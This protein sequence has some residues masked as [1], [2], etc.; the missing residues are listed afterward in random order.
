MTAMMMI[1]LAGARRAGRCLVTTVAVFGLVL[2][3]AT[4]AG[5]ITSEDI[6]PL[7]MGME[8]SGNGLLDLRM[9]SHSGSEITNANGTFNGDNGNATLPNSGGSD[10]S[11]FIESYVTTVGDLQEYY[12]YSFPGVDAE[13]EIELTVFLDL[14]ETT[15]AN[16]ETNRLIKLDIILNPDSIDGSPSPSGDVSG[17][18][19]AAIDQGYTLGAGTK[20]VELSSSPVNLPVNAQGGG[21]GD[22]ALL[23]GI[24]PFDPT[25]NASDVLLFNISMDTL[26]NGG[27]KF[28][29]SGDFSGQNVIE[30]Q[31][32]EPS[33][34]LLLI[35][36]LASLAVSRRRR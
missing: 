17:A 30:A 6:L 21:W 10:D 26:S 4:S 19:Q 14:N 25:L 7:Y 9:I 29:L 28:F 34:A 35:L 31:V 20:I 24:D 22:Y 33:T 11:S 23:T 2:A 36:G 13:G 16:Q 32:P 1:N 15:G 27:E 12:T 18:V 5:T 3:G 8:Q